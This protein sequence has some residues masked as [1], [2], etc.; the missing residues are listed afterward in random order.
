ME[1]PVDYGKLIRAAMWWSALP[2]VTQ[3][4]IWK[5]LGDIYD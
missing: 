1:P 5:D 2:G 3:I 4:A